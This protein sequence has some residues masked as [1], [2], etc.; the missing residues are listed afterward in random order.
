MYQCLIKI[1]HQ[2]HFT[3]AG[4]GLIAVCAGFY[5][6]GC[7]RAY[8]C[9]V[10]VFWWAYVY[11]CVRAYACTTCMYGISVAAHILS[12]SPSL[13]LTPAPTLCRTHPDPSP[14]LNLT[15]PLTLS[16]TS[17][18]ASF[19]PT[20]MRASCTTYSVLD[21]LPF[22]A[23]L[24]ACAW[25]ACVRVRACTKRVGG[26]RACVCACVRREQAVPHSPNWTHC[27]SHYGCVACVC[28][29]ACVRTCLCEHVCVSMCA[30]AH[31]CV[32]SQLRLIA[33]TVVIPLLLQTPP[34]RKQ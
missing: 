30:C 26:V 31:V 33:A 10:G 23:W 29:R 8:V 12:P 6:Y 3:S 4:C 19:P 16:P 13:S 17:S 15:P 20:A 7:V 22:L 27:C 9:G 11:S 28:A 2:G 18:S 21:S 25:V 5:V 32:L 24:C 14:S 1:Q 34:G